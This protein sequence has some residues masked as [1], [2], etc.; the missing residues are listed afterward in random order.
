V[1]SEGR[2][3][4]FPAALVSDA[5]TQL[6]NEWDGT[7][8]PKHTRYV[9]VKGKN[10]RARAVLNACLMTGLPERNG[11]WSGQGGYHNLVHFMED[12]TGVVFE[13]SGSAVAMWSSRVS[14]GPTSL[15]HYMPPI[16]KWAFDPLY[17]RIENMPPATPRLAGPRLTA[18]E[19]VRL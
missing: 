10:A 1:D 18:W 4:A 3:G 19:N 17:G 14:T 15:D 9:G 12:W 8:Y 7:E 16:R 6:S 5:Y 2:R 11:S 13:F